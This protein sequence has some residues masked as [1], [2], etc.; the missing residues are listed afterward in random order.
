MRRRLAAVPGDERRIKA[1][2]DAWLSQHPGA[3]YSE[4]SVA[5]GQY[6]QDYVYD[7]P[8]GDPWLLFRKPASERLKA[9]KQGYGGRA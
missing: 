1:Y 7:G 2:G 6:V 8:L 3:S 9:C 5:I 4:L